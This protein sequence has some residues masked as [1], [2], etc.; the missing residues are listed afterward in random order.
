MK[1]AIL[2][3]TIATALA[4]GQWT[5]EVVDTCFSDRG[6]SLAVAPDGAP[7]FVYAWQFWDS[8]KAWKMGVVLASRV[9]GVWVR[10]TIEQ[11]LADH[12]YHPTVEIDSIGSPHILYRKHNSGLSTLCYARRDSAGWEIDV[13]DSV[14]ANSYGPSFDLALAADGQPHVSYHYLGAHDDCF[15]RHTTLTGDS[16]VMTTLWEGENVSM[17]GAG[18]AVD[19]QGRPHVLY[20]LTLSPSEADTVYWMRGDSSGWTLQSADSVS[21]IVETEIRL[22]S[23]DVP[24]AFT[25]QLVYSYV[26][27]RDHSGWVWDRV[28]LPHLGKLSF[29]LDR[30]GV[31]HAGVAD[32]SG[33]AYYGRR[34]S[35][36]HWTTVAIDSSMPRAAGTG[37]DVGPDGTVWLGYRRGPTELEGHYVVAHGAL[38]VEVSGE[39]RRPIPALPTILRAPDL[40]RL[41]GRVLDITGREVTD[42]KALR[43]GI[44]FVRREGSPDTRKVIL[45]R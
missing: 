29:V 34:E 23:S 16:W 20:G 15:I 4:A 36:G 3:L 21:W 25:R 5:I 32:P 31:I 11:S 6:H 39:P 43:P 38:G 13:V 1:N 17:G 37:L 35:P 40:A 12:Y 7:H 24:V 41:E 26:G 18:V 2:I 44:Y 45:T 22:D 28:P 10:D 30:W 14:Q 33:T 8:E 19:R 27:L 9:G 42:R